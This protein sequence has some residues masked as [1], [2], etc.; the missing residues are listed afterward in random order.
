[1]LETKKF[2]DSMRAEGIGFF[3]GVPDSLLKQICAFIT[4]N[5]DSNNHII[6]ANEGNA[7]A[8]GIGYHIA[9][10]KVPLV[11]MQNSGLGN[12]VN[13]VLS[14]ADKDVY[15]IP[16]LL[17][18]GWRGEPGVAD[19][20]Q[21]VKQGRV[22]KE[23]LEAME[24]PY[25]VIGS[26]LSDA[27]AA[28]I[29]Q[30]AVRTALKNKEPYAL[31][32]RKD[33][34]SDYQLSTDVEVN[35]PLLREDAIKLIASKL[36]DT[37]I[38]VSTTGV[39]SRELF[40]YREEENQGHERDFLTVGGMGHASQIAQGI[41]LQKPDREIYCFDGDGAMLM[42]MGALAIAGNSN[43]PNFRHIIFNNGAHDSVGGQPT[44]GYDLNT[45]ELAKSVGYKSAISAKTESELLEGIETVKRLT[46]PVLLE[47]KVRKGFRK[48][49]GRPTKSPIENKVALMDFLQ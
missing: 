37:D 2:F 48:N 47:V 40:E 39:A 38:V 30:C 4:D 22:S 31:L 11:Y 23:M 10:G 45:V 1:M 43:C 46:G 6:A 34:F 29:V 9:T 20:P 7:I 21:H 44:V 49:L 18:I 19:E 28:A 12:I 27:Q 5:T 24:I 25:E 17:M 35:F 16:M 26:H 33:S 36:G 8:L 42:H 41:A 14:L 32:V 3:S 13:P 15:S